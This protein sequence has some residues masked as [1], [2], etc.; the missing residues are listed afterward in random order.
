VHDNP[1]A[2]LTIRAGGAPRVAHSE[3]VRNGMSE[4]AAGAIVIDA[5]ARPQ[6]SGNVFHGVLAESLTGLTPNDRA[7]VRATNWF[8]AP[9]EPAVRHAQ[10]P[11]RRGGR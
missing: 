3:F 5:G 10:P 7:A 8:L 9:E 1:G 4:R 2:G 11:G 6:L